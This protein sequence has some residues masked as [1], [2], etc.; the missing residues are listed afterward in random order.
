MTHTARIQR[1]SETAKH[2]LVLDEFK[3][4]RTLK[5][6]LVQISCNKPWSIIKVLN[7]FHL[8]RN[9]LLMR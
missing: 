6:H 3:Y 1:V 9:R 5:N 4:I 8:I 2:Q 7:L